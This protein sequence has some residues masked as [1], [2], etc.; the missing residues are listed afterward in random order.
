MN[1]TVL[2]VHVA[3]DGGLLVIDGETGRSAWVTEVELTR[4]LEALSAAGGSVLL[5][6]EHGSPMAGTVIESIKARA[7]I[8]LASEVHPD[9]VRGGGLTSLMSAAYVGA[10]ELA[11]DLLRRGA[12]IEAQDDD[13]FTALMYAANGSQDELVKLLIEA[14]AD[15][16]QADR[17]GSTPLMFGAQHGH[18][19]IVKRLLA[20]G[21]DPSASREAD[22]LTARD[23]AV[24]NGHE[25]VAAVLMAV[26]RQRS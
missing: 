17:A 7:P 8:V 9:A 25:R 5:S 2:Y 1:A 6:R 21:A 11:D 13:G 20:A 3:D 26:E 14:G 10:A 4:R 16:N 18:S 22:G 15:V 12:D 23:F 24:G 19:G